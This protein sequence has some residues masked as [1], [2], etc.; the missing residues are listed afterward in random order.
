M[1]AKSKQYFRKQQNRRNRLRTSM[2]VAVISYILLKIFLA[3]VRVQNGGEIDAGR[4]AEAI[5]KVQRIV[6][7]INRIIAI[8]FKFLLWVVIIVCVAAI[9]ALGYTI[10]GLRTE[11]PW[12]L[13]LEL[14]RFGTVEQMV[15]E[16]G[17]ARITSTIS[18]VVALLVGITYLAI[19]LL[20]N[21]KLWKRRA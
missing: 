10:F 3:R 1:W 13:S 8:W 17:L 7:V 14:W 19:W 9:I 2:L 15:G 18:V 11:A 20:T 4:K 6:D 5:A 21:K 12:L 16:Y